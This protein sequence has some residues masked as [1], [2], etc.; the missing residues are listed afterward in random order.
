[1]PRL[2]VRQFLKN[3]GLTPADLAMV[4]LMR[5]EDDAKERS[6][7]TMTVRE[8]P[9]AVRN[10][11]SAGITAVKIFAGARLRDARASQHASPTSLMARSVTA[12]KKAA[13]GMLVMTETCVC[14]HNDSGECWLADKNGRM[15]VEETIEALGIQ[16]VMQAEAGADIVGPAAMIPGSVR[17]IR[18]VLDVSGHMNVGIMP[19]LIFAS[20]LY[21]GFRTSMGAT[22]RSGVR[23][24][25]IPPNQPEQAMHI[26]R[27]M[28]D[29]G[30]DMILTE[31]ALHTVD[32]LVHLKDK[33]PVPLVPFS[34]SGEFQ[35]LT[36]PGEDGERDVRPL[37]EA[38]TVLKRAGATRIITYAAL[39]MAR[40][41]KVS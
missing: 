15:A 8:L 22:P 13:P 10:L 31:P 24:F 28:V 20:S 25:Q 1:M 5:E 23:A 32:T 21:E 19:H 38:Y 16:A 4:F 12:I 40:H 37:V 9:E 41:L 36:D 2:S 18:E 29:E 17:E 30:A 14:Q 35:R 39:E 33:I 11:E 7:P 26:A 3:P 34:V 6:M 27:Q